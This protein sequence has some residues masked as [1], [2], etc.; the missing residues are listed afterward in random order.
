MKKRTLPIL[1]GALAIA[2]C[3]A[4]APLYASAA[5]AEDSWEWNVTKG[6]V[7]QSTDSYGTVFTSSDEYTVASRKKVWV[8]KF[9]L[10]FRINRD[11]KGSVELVISPT[12]ETCAQDKGIR[13]KA[14]AISDDLLES[15]ITL[16]V[17]GEQKE[18]F[19]SNM[20]NWTDGKSYDTNYLYLAKRDSGWVIN[21]NDNVTA[22]G[23]D[24][25]AALD[26]AL[27]TYQGRVGYLQFGASANTKFT[28]AGVQ[29]GMPRQSGE[30]PQGFGY[31]IFDAPRWTETY[32]EELCGY[33]SDFGKQY[34]VSSTLPMPLNGLT[35]NVRIA[36]GEK[37]MHFF[38]AFT[39]L[40]N[41]NWY[42]GT[43]TIALMVKYNKNDTDGKTDISFM[44]YDDKTD[45]NHEEPIKF[46]ERTDAFKWFETNAIR[47]KKLKGMWLITLNGKELFSGKVSSDG[48][49]VNDYF[50]IVA[51][52]YVGGSAYYQMFAPE[53]SGG[54]GNDGYVIESLKV[55]NANNAPQVEHE[56]MQ[57]VNETQYKAGDTLR[58]NLNELFTDA[59]GDALTLFATKGTIEDGIWTYTPNTAEHIF[60]TF[61]ATDGDA[62]Q[63]IRL[64][65][66]ITNA[67]AQAAEEG[68]SSA[69]GAPSAIIAAVAILSALAIIST[70]GRKNNEN[71]G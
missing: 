36:H 9:G 46:S 43:Y 62:A 8:D 24:A 66:N 41:H 55:Q 68:C 61:T 21:C 42:A 65:F 69:V 48:L 17:A 26:T 4:V 32:G 71:V 10:A 31:E 54:V 49:N 2:V 64:E 5:F 14:E 6:D 3:I 35:A 59:D 58:I 60:V 22:L 63:E 16:S 25:S 57:K 50:N 53:S 20:F 1:L 30:N 47:V 12:E 40:N 34:A 28:Y 29:Y 18:K 37:N 11:T 56:V 70:K 13:L 52:Y 38:M 44:M 27:T 67:S 19:E 51:P 45:A 33:A 39:S 7:T 23:G 15:E